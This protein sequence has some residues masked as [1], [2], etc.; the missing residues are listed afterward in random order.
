[1]NS[2]ECEY[3]RSCPDYEPM[4]I[5]CNLFMIDRLFCYRFVLLGNTILPERAEGTERL[6]EGNSLP[7]VMSSIGQ[8][9]ADKVSL[10][11]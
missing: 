7:A 1:M 8:G 11:A 2:G 10:P 6:R 3:S 9:L 4:G 5:K